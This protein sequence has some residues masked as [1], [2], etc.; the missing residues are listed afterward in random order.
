MSDLLLEQ[1]QYQKEISMEKFQIGELDY[2]LKQVE[3]EVFAL[4][5]RQMTEKEVCESLRHATFVTD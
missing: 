2:L 1:E 5:S 4:K 3:K